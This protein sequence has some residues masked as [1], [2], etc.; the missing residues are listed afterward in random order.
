M[1]ESHEVV[2][3]FQSFLET[4]DL[5]FVQMP[6]LTLIAAAMILVGLGLRRSL[7]SL[8]GVSVIFAHYLAG[9]FSEFL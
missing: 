8:A 4:V 6:R 3:F 2:A 1:I 9:T 5:G 7:L